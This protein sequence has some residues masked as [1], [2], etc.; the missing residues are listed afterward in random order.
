MAIVIPQSRNND[1]IPRFKIAVITDAGFKGGGA[2]DFEEDELVELFGSDSPQLAFRTVDFIEPAPGGNRIQ[3]D[4]EILCIERAHIVAW[5]I[6]KIKRPSDLT[7][8]KRLPV[9]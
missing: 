7:I 1:G 2:V 9:A 6:S 3:Y 8:A 5:A 4:T